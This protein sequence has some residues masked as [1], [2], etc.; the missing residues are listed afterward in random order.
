MSA[1]DC[2]QGP[3]VIEDFEQILPNDPYVTLS[4]N[5]RNLVA[6]RR[7]GGATVTVKLHDAF[8]PAAAAVHVTFVPP[9]GNGEP[10]A[11]VQLLVRPGPPAATG[12][13]YETP[14]GP[15]PGETTVMDAGHMMP[16]LGAAG[17]AQLHPKTAS[18]IATRR[19]RASLFKVD[20]HVAAEA[21]IVAGGGVEFNRPEKTR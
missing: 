5:A 11:G 15:P 14:S 20:L 17:L 12:D 1:S 3:R 18:A 8:C 19:W 9:S 10:L 16:G 21:A 6:A 4:P 13:G 7:G 2:I